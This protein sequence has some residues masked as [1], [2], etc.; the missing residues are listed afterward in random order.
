[1]ASAAEA[2]RRLSLEYT[3][4]GDKEAAAGAKSVATAV[5]GVAVASTRAEKATQSLD[6]RL[7]SIQ[8][9]YDEQ[10]RSQ[11]ELA[12]VERT[13][14]SAQAQGL[15]T[16]QRRVELLGMAAERHGLAS[17]AIA[18]ETAQVEQ[19]TAAT[20]RLGAANDNRWRRQNLTYQLF[21][22][23]Q[24]L[25]LGQNPAMTA[26]QQG[27]QIAQLYAGNGG[28]NAA[29]KETG[30]LLGGIVKAFPVT[31]ALTVAA[32]VA[33]GGLA[34]EINQTTD[35]AVGF[36]DVVMGTIEALAGVIY[37]QLKPA[38][39]AVSPWFAAA[40]NSV[41]DGTKLVGN[42]IINSFRAAFEDLKL[43]FTQFPNIVAVAIGGAA[44]LVVEAVERMI[45]LVTSGLDAVI[46]KVN[47]FAPEGLQL[48]TIG[49]VKL[50]RVDLGSAPAELA[51]AGRARNQNIADIMGSDPLGGFFDRVR[52]ESIENALSGQK[53]KKAGKSETER[54]A[55]RYAAIV[56]D[57]KQATQAFRD[58]EAA[59]YMTEEAA[60]R[61]AAQQ[62][63]LNK[64][65]D[66][67]IKLTGAQRE[68]LLTL[69][70]QMAEAEMSYK[71]AQ[72]QMEFNKD[73][74]RGFIQDLTQGIKAG[75]NFWDAFGDAASNALDK[76]TDKLLNEVLDALFQVNSAGSKG[77]GG[78][79]LLGSLFGGLFGGG[80]SFFPAAP[81]GGVGVG[82]L[83]A[84]GAAFNH[85]NVIPFARGGIVDHPTLFPMANGAGLMG[86]AGPEAIMPLRRGA[87]GKLGVA[88]AN[89]N[90]SSRVVIDVNVSVDD[91][92]KLSVIAR[93]A[94]AQGGQEQAD[95]RI[96]QYD[97]ALPD[98][99]AGINRNP[100]RR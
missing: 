16:M 20:Q 43:I 98:R 8:R 45:N 72:E 7:N 10:F 1:M 79:G 5:D 34:Y 70:A 12:R 85:G 11:M 4:K 38:I 78:G 68:E 40:W 89:Q 61:L 26:L 21:D 24:M 39:D 25:A 48:G 30:S 2:K 31:T 46:K 22:V 56:R 77:G 83:F 59:L 14:A 94:G 33:F 93:Q 81:T 15:I 58:Q 96:N 19:L 88:A 47:E 35:V 36:G 23:G 62:D 50:G 44:N 76:I 90:G 42:T 57:S 75:E 92:G 51:A 71:R 13:L 64:A 80:K 65:Q 69:G 66:A 18:R 9:R 87:D 99:V 95:I 82:G 97:T 63:L 86:E 6:G 74:A 32:G 84:D 3:S 54:L 37:D 67:G 91:D 41:I 28:V 17:A 52:S 100:R 55:E 60:A 29:L 53:D 27:P 49:E 73:L